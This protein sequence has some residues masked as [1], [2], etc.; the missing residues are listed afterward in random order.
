MTEEKFPFLVLETI[1]DN[2]VIM[3]YGGLLPSEQE[4]AS[5]ANTHYETVSH[6]RWYELK[7]VN[8]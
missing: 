7:E 1:V 2:G 4:I 6:F 3:V 8:R 5:K